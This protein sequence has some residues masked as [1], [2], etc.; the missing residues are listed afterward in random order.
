MEEMK[1]FLIS[2]DIY[3]NKCLYQIFIATRGKNENRHTGRTGCFPLLMSFGFLLA[4]VALQLFFTLVMVTPGSGDAHVHPPLIDKPC[5]MQ[6]DSYPVL[7][8]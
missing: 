5:P 7:S 8:T 3:S 6:G 1:R 4:C 2:M